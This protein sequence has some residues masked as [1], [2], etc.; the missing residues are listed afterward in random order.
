MDRG[1]YREPPRWSDQEGPEHFAPKAMRGIKVHIQQVQVMFPVDSGAEYQ[2]L[3][4]DGQ[5]SPWKKAPRQDLLKAPPGADGVRWREG[6]KK[7]R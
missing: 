4:A 2:W 3:Y 1:G 6:A 5:T 7:K